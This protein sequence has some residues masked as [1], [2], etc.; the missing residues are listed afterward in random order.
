MLTAPLE[1]TDADQQ[2]PIVLQ[3]RKRDD[4]SGV[5]T[6]NILGR[7]KAELLLV[8]LQGSE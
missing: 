2:L 7:Y 3:G 5:L 8:K 1:K 6:L 4:E